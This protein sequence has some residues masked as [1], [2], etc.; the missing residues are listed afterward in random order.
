MSKR[1]TP[2]GWHGMLMK[3]E[4]VQATIEGRKTQ[5]RRIVKNQHEL[6]LSMD[7]LVDRRRDGEWLGAFHP[8]RGTFSVDCPYGKVADRIWVRETFY[9]DDYRYPDGPVGE[10]RELL[11]YRAGHECRNWEQGCPCADEEGRSHW[12]SSMLMPWW[13]SRLALEITGLRVERLQEITEVDA[14][15]EGF[16]RCADCTDEDE[17]GAWSHFREAWDKINGHRVSDF[18]W[19]GNPW[20]WVIGYRKLDGKP[21]DLAR[22]EED[23][24][25]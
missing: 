12:R 14:K 10:M 9:C 24:F 2:Q 4:L 23:L 7:G 19:D 5:T 13:A 16:S 6:Q 15:R 8:G 17:H 1:I 3:G 25:R 22:H 20:V 11:E 21:M 18:W